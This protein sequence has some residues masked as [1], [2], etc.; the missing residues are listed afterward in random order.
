MSHVLRCSCLEVF[1]WDLSITVGGQAQ[2]H[3][4]QNQRA[5]PKHL[6]T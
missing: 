1:E 4:G 2:A 5:F 6:N 3:S